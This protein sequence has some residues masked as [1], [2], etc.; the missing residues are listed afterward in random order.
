MVIE[1]WRQQQNYSEKVGVLTHKKV[2][3]DDR[4]GENRKE[5]HHFKKS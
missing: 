4:E 3:D 5:Q 2:N 1:K